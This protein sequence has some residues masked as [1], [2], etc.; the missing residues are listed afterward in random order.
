MDCPNCGAVQEANEVCRLCGIV[1]E[2][3]QVAVE[4]QLAAAIT[5]TAPPSPGTPPLTEAQSGYGRGFLPTW[6]GE[7][8]LSRKALLTASSATWR[9]F[10]GWLAL[11]LGVLL[12]AAAVIFF[13]ACN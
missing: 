13:F 7:R 12:L 6:T 4:G 8:R 1:V 10:L 3:F 2:K 9:R 11:W 5:A